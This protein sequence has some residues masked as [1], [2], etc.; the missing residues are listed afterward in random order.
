MALE[1]SPVYSLRELVALS[2]HLY[3]RK[4]DLYHSTHYVLPAWVGSKVVVT[5][6]D[7]IHL[8]YP[9]FLPSNFAFLYA[10][11]M[12]R[13]SLH[14]GDRIIAVSQNTKTDLMHHFDVDGRKIQVVYNGVEDVFRR[15][16]AARGAGALA[17][18]SGDRAAL[19][20]LRGQSGQAAQEP[21]HRRPGLRAG[22]ADGAVRRAAGLRR[23]P[24]GV[25]VQD[26]PARRVP[27]DRRQG[28][29]ARPRGARGAAGDL[30]GSDAVPLPHALRGVRAAGDRGDGLGGGGDHLEHLGAQGDRGGV[31]AAGR[32]A[33]PR[34]HGQGD[35]PPDGEPRAPRR[36]HRAGNE[37]RRGLP[38]GPDGA[39]DA[40]DLSASVIGGE[41]AR[42]PRADGR[43][44]PSRR[45]P[46]CGW[47]WSTTG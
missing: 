40:R 16:A 30:P 23:Q 36:L 42:D 38:L 35:R 12:I 39:A 21:R 27:G 18:R 20:P 7:I 8:L 14:R 28:P 29:P 37:A 13:R 17:A 9:E 34:R 26:P 25:G 32:S 24:R 31:R 46:G 43:R 33:G 22:A 41:D 45:R 19:S 1:S 11:R 5:I 3:R 15:R 4:L 10:Q 6:H 2:W 44:S 47:R